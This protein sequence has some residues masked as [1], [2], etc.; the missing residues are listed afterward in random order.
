MLAVELGVNVRVAK[1]GTLF[2]DVGKAID[3]EVQGSH[4]DIGRR[5]LQKFG[6]DEN[7]VKLCRLI[8]VNILMK[9]K[10]LLFR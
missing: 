2:H 6:V 4:V 9:L 1:M 7:V 5:I 3:H 10:V 8:M